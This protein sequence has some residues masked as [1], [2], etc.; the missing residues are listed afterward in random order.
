MKQ[1]KEQRRK[2]ARLARI[3]PGELWMDESVD[4]YTLVRLDRMSVTRE[5]VDRAERPELEN[6]WI[7]RLPEEP[8]V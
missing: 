1:S 8:V 3:D 5:L 7:R 2:W 4:A 6:P